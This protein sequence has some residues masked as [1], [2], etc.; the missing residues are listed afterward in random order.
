MKI[1]FDIIKR[2]HNVLSGDVRSNTKTWKYLVDGIEVE[3]ADFGEDFD[4]YG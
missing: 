1:Y 3:D 4:Y 2:E